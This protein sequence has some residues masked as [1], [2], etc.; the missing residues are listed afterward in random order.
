MDYFLLRLLLPI[1]LGGFLI[2]WPFIAKFGFNRLAPKEGKGQKERPG[3]L[4]WKFPWEPGLSKKALAEGYF[5]F[6]KGTAIWNLVPSL[7]GLDWVNYSFWSLV[8]V[9]RVGFGIGFIPF[10]NWHLTG[11]INRGI[12][13]LA[14]GLVPGW[15]LANQILG[16]YL[17][18]VG[19]NGRN[20]Y[21]HF[22]EPSI[23]AYGF[24]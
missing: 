18:G 11:P 8:G 16:F 1:G 4:D 2:I 12:V 3:P 15:V 6:K 24:S 13:E 21:T 7:T 9:N 22:F 23:K 19:P 10:Q 17:V 20:S 14:G 5:P